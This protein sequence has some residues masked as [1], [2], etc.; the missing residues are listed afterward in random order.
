MY[1]ANKNTISLTNYY[2]YVEDQILQNQILQYHSTNSTKYGFELQNTLN[3]N[4]KISI[5]LK[6]NNTNA[7]IESNNL[8]FTPGKKIPGIPN[9]IALFNVNY[10][11][12]N[13]GN[14]N[15][16]HAWKKQMYIQNDINNNFSQKQPAYNSTD[17]SFNY[18]VEKFKKINEMEIFGTITNIFNQ[19]N[20]QY[21]SQDELY[22]YNFET[23]YMVGLK[24]I[25]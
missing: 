15:F 5:N 21:I 7:N 24:L 6:L 22:P 13:N 11:F 18:A 23:A 2:S 9:N 4:D 25:F 20:V 3:F 1:Q 10:K 16:N 14:I 8:I 17:I 19:K 12:L